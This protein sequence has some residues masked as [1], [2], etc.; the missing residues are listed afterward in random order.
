MWWIT[1]SHL[2]G[3]Q[4]ISVQ[5]CCLSRHSN[6]HLWTYS[7]GIKAFQVQYSGTYR[8][9]VHHFLYSNVNGENGLE[10]RNAA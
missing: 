3:S 5:H 2:W 1:A 9:I 6:L 10:V 8:Q 4:L 7:K